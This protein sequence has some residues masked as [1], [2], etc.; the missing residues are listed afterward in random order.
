M[1]RPDSDQWRLAKAHGDRAELAIAEWFR[2][3]G[4]EPYKTL[5]TSAFDLL[6]QCP[7]E[8]KNDMR[9]VETGN[10]AI[11]THFRGKPSGILTSRATYWA[12]VVAREAF[13]VKTRKLREL[14]CGSRYRQAQAG[15]GAAA[16]VRLLPVEELRSWNFV[17]V[18]PLPELGERSGRKA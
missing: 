12:I 18:V 8:V 14:V 3:R 5:G 11:E 9:A 16:T 17:R 1:I 4:F 6:L 13:I 7:V 15:D 2:G 10:V